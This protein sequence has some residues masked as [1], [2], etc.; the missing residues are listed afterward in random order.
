MQVSNDFF[1]SGSALVSELVLVLNQQESNLNPIVAENQY[2]VLCAKGKALCCIAQM[3]A[4][5]TQSTITSVNNLICDVDNKL[6]IY[7]LLCQKESEDV[8][9]I[10]NEL[11]EL[12]QEIDLNVK[13]EIHKFEMRTDGYKPKQT[14]G[15]FKN[16]D[17]Q[18]HGSGVSELKKMFESN[19]S[20]SSPQDTTKVNQSTNSTVNTAVID[21]TAIT[22]PVTADTVST[23]PS[24]MKQNLPKEEIPPTIPPLPKE[25][26]PPTRPP[27]PDSDSDNS[28]P[29]P[30]PLPVLPHP[31]VPPCPP[32]PMETDEEEEQSDIEIHQVHEL[33]PSHDSHVTEDEE[34][35][36]PLEKEEKI[37]LRLTR[38]LSPVFEDEEEGKDRPDIGWSSYPRRN[39]KK[40]SSDD[41]A[42]W[43]QAHKQ[44]LQSMRYNLINEYLRINMQ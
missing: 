19:S 11:D 25:E 40:M 20:P 21:S 32:S 8:F 10:T 31:Q 9:V 16:S 27:L 35:I 36:V 41:R 43:A 30:P 6:S 7:L 17:S 38:I 26:A 34:Y 4:E 5:A 37:D 18:K 2:T 33:K 1:S 12:L 24:L 44:S 29:T 13:D 39:A 14:F 15:I 3:N 23:S 22:T 28:P 42:Q